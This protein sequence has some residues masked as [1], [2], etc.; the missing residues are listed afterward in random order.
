[1]IHYFNP[2]HETAVHNASPYYMAPANV[3]AMQNELSFLPAWY[4]DAGDLV[5]TDRYDEYLYDLFPRLP[6]AIKE[7]EITLY[8]GNEVC[9]WGIS[10]QSVHY[11]H[12]LDK[13]YDA[14]L[15]IPSFI[16]EYIYLNSRQS[17][18]DVLRLIVDNIPEI[19]SEI[20]PCVFTDLDSIEEY[21][22]QSD[23]KL[24]AKAPYSSSGRGL[25]WLPEGGL[26]RTEKQILNGILKKQGAVSVEKVLD[27]KTDFAMEF[28]SDGRGGINF[29]GYSLF[30]TNKKGAYESNYIGSQEKIESMLTENISLLLLKKVK[31]VV[32]GILKERYAKIYKGCIGVDM[33]IYAEGEEYKLQPCVEINM[34]YN[35]GYLAI[36]LFENYIF[37]GSAGRFYMDFD[38]KEG[39]TYQKHLQIQEQYPLRV[40]NE[41]II[42]GYLSLCPITEQNR[43]R[44]YVIIGG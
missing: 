35:M 27:K 23:I 41:R 10:P 36:K 16:E 37:E 20:L 2:G 25:L 7:S 32:Q 44:A 29:A 11:F 40:E 12:E 18:G 15:V 8:K 22:A 39:V 31:N 9:L 38:A 19:S 5:L 6:K 3:V 24:L 34:R 33:M 13:L 1:M 21:V 26:T 14:Q 17:A 42:R 4:G 28:I 30:Y 43:Y